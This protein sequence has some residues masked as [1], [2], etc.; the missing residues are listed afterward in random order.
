MGQP[1]DVSRCK[2]WIEKT[3]KAGRALQTS[4][5]K[6]IL[7]TDDPFPIQVELQVPGDTG[8]CAVSTDQ[9]ASF[10][11]TGNCSAAQMDYQSFFVE[12]M[13]DITSFRQPAHPC[14]QALI[15]IAAIKPT[16]PADAKLVVLADQLQLSS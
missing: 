11:G 16:H 13:I 4:S 14:A 5:G 9:I 7:H 8:L 6:D 12:D 1:G 10:H 3:K 15:Q 2:L